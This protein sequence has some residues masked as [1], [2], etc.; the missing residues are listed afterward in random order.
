MQIEHVAL[1]TRDLEGLVRF[2]QTYFEAEAGPMYT[3]PAK[4]FESYFLSFASGARLELMRIPDLAEH[5][6]GEP[7]QPAGYSHL[8]FSTGSQAAVDELTARLRADGYRVISGPRTTG[9]G[10]YES[11]VEDPDGNRVEITV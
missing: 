6:G 1:W 10:Y 4:G 11:L 3:N 7:P 2:Y 9:D 5:P 8:A